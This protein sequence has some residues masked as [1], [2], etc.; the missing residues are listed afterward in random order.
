M[1][2]EIK[3]Y[4]EKPEGFLPQVEVA[5]TY[6]HLNGKLLLLENASHKQEAGFWGVPAGKLEAGER[7]TEGAKRELFEETGIDIHLH[8]FHSLGVLY[9]RK[10]EIDYIYHPFSVRL[11][12]HHPVYLSSEHTS[13]QWVLPPEAKSLP[14]MNASNEALDAF[15]KHTS[16][17]NAGETHDY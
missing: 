7:P 10:P 11:Q 2:T 1:N 9:I 12:T 8:H 5:A 6:I 4:H 15:L 13:Y 14:L 3:V 16:I 17:L